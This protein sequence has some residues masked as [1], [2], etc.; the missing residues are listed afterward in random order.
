[1]PHPFSVRPIAV[2]SHFFPFGLR[3][4]GGGALPVAR[5]A[6]TADSK[7]SGASDTLAD[8]SVLDRFF[9]FT[10]FNSFDMDR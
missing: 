2:I 1:M 3:F 6:R 4:G 7:S 8:E 9:R 5:V 10:D